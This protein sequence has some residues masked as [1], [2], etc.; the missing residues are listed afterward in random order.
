[1]WCPFIPPHVT[2][3]FSTGFVRRPRDP[4]G[5]PLVRLYG[6]PHTGRRGGTLAFNFYDAS[7]RAIDHREVERRA[8][9]RKI[10]LRSG[11]FGNPGA[12]ELA[13][14][15]SRG[16]LE[17]CFAASPRMTKEGLRSCID[18]TASGAARVSLSLASNFADAHALV[19]LV[20][21]LTETRA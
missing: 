7:D 21:T 14:G 13:L 1:M 11:C 8:A 15:L 17:K 16:E 12:G 19:T 4:N 2:A 9:G 20:A 10:S 18:P 5:E 3:S 6:P